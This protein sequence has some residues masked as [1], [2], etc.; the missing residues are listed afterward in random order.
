MCKCT[1]EWNDDQ[2]CPH[3]WIAFI[4]VNLKFWQPLVSFN[5][6]PQKWDNNI[7][8]DSKFEY[9]WYFAATKEW[10]TVAL[11]GC[12]FK[13]SYLTWPTN[14]DLASKLPAISE[15]D[16]NFWMCCIYSRTF[17]WVAFRGRVHCIV[18]CPCFLAH[19]THKCNQSSR[20]K[21]PFASIFY[22]LDNEFF[23]SDKVGYWVYR[24]TWIKIGLGS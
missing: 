8:F 14:L 7:Y 10:Q 20:E 13:L 17:E 4:V 2:W 3:A 19:L 23:H 9:F 16:S 6:S 22:K 24:E 5:K 15:S 18:A 1:K 12:I 11:L 21:N